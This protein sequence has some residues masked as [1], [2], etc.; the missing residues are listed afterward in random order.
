MLDPKLMRFSAAMS[1]AVITKAI[2]IVSGYWIG[3]K[4]DESWQTKPL[5]TLILALIGFV[6]GLWYLVL[7]FNRTKP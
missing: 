1:S 6:M 3:A 4:L 5:F 7:I 2:L